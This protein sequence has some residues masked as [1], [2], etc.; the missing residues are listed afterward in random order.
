MVSKAPSLT[1]GFQIAA[2]V[3]VVLGIVAG[4]AMW[5]LFS[6][7]L[8]ISITDNGVAIQTLFL[9]EYCTPVSSLAFFEGGTGREVVRLVAKCDSAAMYTV[10]VHAGTNEFRGMYLDGYSVFYPSGVPYSFQTGVQYKVVARWRHLSSH[11]LFEI[12]EKIRTANHRL[13]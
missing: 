13:H 4:T 2:F 1:K 8:T 12:P 5:Q 11:S 10:P 9:G 3:L 6:D 7:K